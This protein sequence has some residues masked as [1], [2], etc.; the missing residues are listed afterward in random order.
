MHK[1]GPDTDTGVFMGYYLRTGC[2]WTGYYLVASLSAFD[3]K[4]LIDAVPPGQCRIHVQVV[5]K[6]EVYRGGAADGSQATAPR[7]PTYV[8]PLK[9][10]YERSNR[11]LE[12]RA[13]A[14]RTVVEE[15]EDTSPGG[16]PTT[17]P[18]A[19]EQTSHPFGPGPEEASSSSGSR[20]PAGTT[21]VD[22]EPE[23]LYQ[24]RL[25]GL[26][27]GIS[28]RPSGHRLATK[29]GERVVISKPPHVDAKQWYDLH[30]D[31]RL[32]FLNEW[33]KPQ[34]LR[35][36]KTWDQ[37][38]IF[39]K[40]EHIPESFPPD[41]HFPWCGLVEPALPE[42]VLGSGPSGP[43]TPGPPATAA[44]DEAAPSAAAMVFPGGGGHKT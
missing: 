28:Y 17:V 5:D 39:L 23:D 37:M 26:I 10:K 9:Q 18:T 3:N 38:K 8:F 42:D 7:D 29:K 1:F 22:A 13:E 27:D 15:D 36:A 40:E 43:A 2:R 31:E 4:P 44:P 20:D 21:I 16:G 35:L 14:Q 12:G 30:Y 19:D 34:H 11:T 32:S 33:R 41:Y 24:T 6:V 25:K